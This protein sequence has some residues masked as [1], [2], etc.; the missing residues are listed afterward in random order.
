MTD[1]PQ[2]RRSSKNGS[3]SKQ[4]KPKSKSPKTHSAASIVN[5]SATRTIT[6]LLNRRDDSDFDIDETP[7][8]KL[9]FSNIDISEKNLSSHSASAQGKGKEVLGYERDLEEREK[10]LQSA[11]KILQRREHAVDV[12]LAKIEEK[13]Q[14]AAADAQR[15]KTLHD[16][17]L[18][19]S[20]KL[21]T[22]VEMQRD[23]IIGNEAIHSHAINELKRQIEM[24]EATL[25]EQGIS[26]GKDSA[27]QSGTSPCEDKGKSMV[28]MAEPS[29]S[30]GLTQMEHGDDEIK[31]PEVV[32]RTDEAQPDPIS[33]VGKRTRS[34]EDEVT[35]PPKSA[36]GKLGKNIIKYNTYKDLSFE[37]QGTVEFLTMSDELKG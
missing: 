26:A 31:S 8:A 18:E 13:F 9:D 27:V 19:I 30:L 36:Q 4:N 17:Q 33:Y 22:Q 1:S 14:A 35:P 29:F 3:S 2:P 16:E 20:K 37:N 12:W 34:H 5:E 32:N 23:D 7:I 24:L 21:Q 15:W 10:K 6:P 11:E 28:V 25:K